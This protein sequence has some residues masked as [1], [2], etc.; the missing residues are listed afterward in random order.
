MFRFGSLLS[1]PHSSSNSDDVQPLQLCRPAPAPPFGLSALSW[2][3]HSLGLTRKSKKN[4]KTNKK[5]KQ[6]IW[7]D[8][9][10]YCEQLSKSQKGGGRRALFL[11][12]RLAEK[13]S[14]PKGGEKKKKKDNTT[15]QMAP[16]RS[17]S[18]PRCTEKCITVLSLRHNA[19]PAPNQDG[20]RKTGVLTHC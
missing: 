15:R 20:E 12:V 10:S 13:R 14:E 18:S 19:E 17:F 3:V 1:L 6:Q 4:K 5:L 7:A 2:H 8:G 11:T 9:D 16:S